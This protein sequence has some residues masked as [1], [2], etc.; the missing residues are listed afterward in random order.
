MSTL[1]IAIIRSTR[2]AFLILT[3][4]CVLL[5]IAAAIHLHGHIEPTLAVLVLLGS[6]AA[7]VAANALNEYFDFTSGLDIHTHKTPF[8]GGSG[9]LPAQPQALAWVLATALLALALTIAIGLYLV[10]KVGATLLAVGVVGV[11]IILLYTRTLNRLPWLCLVAPGLAFGPLIVLGTYIS[12]S[13]PSSATASSYAQVLLLSLVP[14]FL[15][16]NLLLLN[17][18]PDISADRQAGRRTFPIQYG[19][20]ASLQVYLVFL[21][22]TGVA[23]LAAVFSGVAPKLCLTALVCLPLGFN[24]YRGVRA[25]QLQLPG[26]LPYLGRNVA[27]TLL[28][29]LLYAIGLLFGA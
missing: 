15:V 8:S 5:G 20:A 18:L 28:T 17:Q 27:V 24:I 19:P 4:V 1:P 14:F 16:N 29:P 3:P 9:A 13:P 22:A 12:V 11:I 10:S 25:A 6:L 7:H 2:P 23:L 21:L 26:I